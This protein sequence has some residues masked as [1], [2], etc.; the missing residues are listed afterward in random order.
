MARNGVRWRVGNR[1]SDRFAI[2]VALDRIGHL[3]DDDL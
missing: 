2:A 1:D 3:E